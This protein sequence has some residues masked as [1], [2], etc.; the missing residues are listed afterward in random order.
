VTYCIIRSVRLAINCAAA[1]SIAAN[2][3][4]P[5]TLT[6]PAQIADH[7]W[8]AVILVG[9]L[10]FCG[11]AAI[12]LTVGVTVPRV[13]D[14]FSYLLAADTFVQGRLTNPTHPMWVHFES[15][16]IIQQPSYMS[17]Y[18]PG[19]GL[20]LAAGKVLGGH[21]IVGVWLS[22]GLMCAAICWM[23]YA[24]LPP[25]WALFGALLAVIHPFL[26]IGSY[27]AQGYWG[28][29]VAT[30]GGALVL[31]GVRRL[32]RDPRVL[33]SSRMSVG[34]GIL[35]ISRPYEGLL[36]SLPVA[37]FIFIWMFGKRGPATTTSIGRIVLP[38]ILIV[39][40]I[41]AAMGIYNFKVTGDPL[42]MPYQ[43]HEET[44]AMGPLFIWQDPRPEP[45][46][47][48]Q[49]IRDFH[50]DFAMPLYDFKSS[51]LRFIVIKMAGL[52][53]VAFQAL[54]I[55]VIPLIGRFTTVIAW[56]MRNR[57]ARRAIVIY[58]FL[59]LALLTESFLW[60]HY[61]AP[62]IG[63]NY[64]FALIAMRLWQ[65]RNKRV[66][67]LITRLIPIFTLAIT[68]LLTISAASQDQSNAWYHRRA[69]LLRRLQAQEGKHLIVVSYGA[70]HSF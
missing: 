49:V 14:E 16:H 7:Q 50:K 17:K 53:L 45:K 31:G 22:F 30:T 1:E 35:A 25:R 48:H 28:G 41:A 55:L 23:L 21:P 37:V 19:Q 24:W 9:L 18:P 54:H 32:T 61:L 15:F 68:L 8:L 10:A 43:I 69:E 26:G 29:A 65:W 3:L 42:R 38:V 62:I 40:V 52:F 70:K 66:G 58:C 6:K 2:F 13:H 47:H 20:I 34:L 56:T 57:W 59:T 11:S 67:K 33:Y 64:F 5:P 39:A 60:V 27:W 12:G 51:P 4:P 36:A 63:L 44:Y 46:Y